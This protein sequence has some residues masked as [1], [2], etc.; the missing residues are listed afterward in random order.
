MGLMYGADYTKV[1]NDIKEMA[2]QYT[3]KMVE[4]A[5]RVYTKVEK[6]I[7]SERYLV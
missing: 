4:E 6:K 1:A 3:K 2:Q 5:M 7:F